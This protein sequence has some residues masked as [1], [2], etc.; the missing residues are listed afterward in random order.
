MSEVSPRRSNTTFVAM[1]PQH[2]DFHTLEKTFVGVG[3]SLTGRDKGG[4]G[5]VSTEDRTYRRC[6]PVRAWI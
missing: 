2:F 3:Q 4:R 6:C 5:V 1:C